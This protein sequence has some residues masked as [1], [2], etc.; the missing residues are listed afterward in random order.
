MSIEIIK[1]P[2]WKGRKSYLLYFFTL[3]RRMFNVEWWTGYHVFKL[4]FL[5]IKL[6]WIFD[7]EVKTLDPE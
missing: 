1:G 5:K 2:N 3:S 6:D 7:S 4:Q